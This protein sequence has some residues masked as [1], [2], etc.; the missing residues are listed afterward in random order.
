[1]CKISNNAES[2]SGGS[3]T[4][5]GPNSGD[6]SEMF[7]HI[8]SANRKVRTIQILR[9][10]GFKIEKNY[11]RPTWSNN[12]TCPLPGHKGAKERTPSFGYCFVSDHWN[13]F[14]GETRVLTWEGSREIRDLVGQTHRVLGRR[15]DWVDAKFK[16]YGKQ[17][18]WK[19]TI[20]RNRQV[21]TI[22]ATADH[23]WFVRSGEDRRNTKEILTKNLK[24]NYRLSYIFPRCHTSQMVLSPFGI[25]HG[26]VFGDGTATESG[27]FGYLIGEKDAQL[28]KW[29]PL[30]KITPRSDREDAFTVH[31]LPRFFKQRPPLDEAAQYLFGWLA[32]YFAADGCVAKDG[33]VMLNSADKEN[34]EFART[35]C[36][37]LGI[38]TYGITKQLREG[39]PGNEPSDLYRIHLINED[40]VPDFFLIDEHRKRFEA[41]DKKFTRRGWVVNSVEQ[42]N[43]VE[44]VYCAEV[45]DGHAFSLEDNI[46]TGNCFGCGKS[47]RAVEFIALYEQTSRTLVAEKILAQYGDDADFEEDN[48]Y[49]DD[50]SPI[51]LE[52]SKYLQILIQKH[53]DNPQKLKEINRYIWWL[54]FYLMAKAPRNHISPEDLK[55]RIDRM[56]E[57]L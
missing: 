28:S 29:F 34:L 5:Q 45:E 22:Y 57:V 46:L 10:Y 20:T 2:G 23:R 21:K 16:A 18:L 8:K 7:A 13:C 49:I 54:D 9:G 35:V 27:S 32:G 38:G 11:Q 55:Y 43:R 50:I 44:E 36:T 33:T 39:F 6:N 1:M 17:N 4:G 31:N 30:N 24:R 56:K 3:G 51:L 47:G 12:I 26:I 14:S 52:G 40:L 42:T 41:A 19:I 25:A 15:A 53:K 37:R 48:D